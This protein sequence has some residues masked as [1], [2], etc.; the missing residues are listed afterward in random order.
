[1]WACF[2][3]GGWDYYQKPNEIFLKQQPK[4]LTF[5]T[6][7]TDFGNGSR[8]DGYVLGWTER[9]SRILHPVRSLASIG[10]AEARCFRDARVAPP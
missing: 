8:G 6:K 10:F 5:P 4:S 9:E 3:C 1:M 2:A 7:W